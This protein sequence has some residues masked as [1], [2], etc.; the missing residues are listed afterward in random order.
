[1]MLTSTVGH[2]QYTKDDL[3]DRIADFQI[4][5]DLFYEA[6][7]FPAQRRW[8]FFSKP[9]EDNTIFFT[10]SIVSTLRMIRED[11]DEQ[12]R[13]E[14]D[15]IISNAI[16]V[17]SN[18]ASR[19]GGVTYNFWPTIPPDL[20]FP[21]GSKL[22]SN[23]DT[24]LPDDFDSTVLAALAQPKNDSVDALI[25]T[26]M[27]EY[28]ARDNRIDVKLITPDEYQNSQAYEV[29]FGKNM[30]Q[31]FDICVMSNILLY[32]FDRG[33]ELNRYD[34]AS[35]SLVQGMILNDDH[36]E[37]ISDVSHQ[38][39]SSALVLYHVA[40]LIEADKLG[41]FK[42][43]REVVIEDLKSLLNDEENE[44]ERVMILSSLYRLGQSIEG[45]VN[46]EKF[47]KDAKTF[48]FFSF[49]PGSLGMSRYLPTFKWVCEAYNWTMLLELRVMEKP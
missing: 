30:P 13:G 33:F 15:A 11:L 14:V 43:I 23:E 18:Y 31:T 25:R 41:L 46:E 10:A 26:V 38:S 42:S 9:V 49:D 28:A 36:L 19:S 48:E 6:G 27:T 32:V 37:R 24:R 12:H 47:E 34:S 1:M 44:V 29:W 35:I 39:S 45:S 17:F 21:N 40:R 16:P 5:Q 7:L 3:V 20:P 4:Q 22:I 2:S 8:F